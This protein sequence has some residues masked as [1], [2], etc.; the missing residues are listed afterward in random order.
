M[1]QAVFAVFLAFL[2]AWTHAA[3]ESAPAK[4]LKAIQADQ[5]KVSEKFS[6]DYGKAKTD[7]DRKK[8]FEAMQKE[9]QKCVRRALK[10]ATE[11]PKDPAAFEARAWIV[12]GG[13][14]FFPETWLALDQIREYD[15]ANPKI[16]RVCLHARIFRNFYAGTEDFLRSVIKQNPDHGVQGLAV[17]SLA[18]VLQDYAGV[19]ERLKDPAKTTPF[20][21]THPRQLVERLRAIT[22]EKLRRESEELY[23]RAADKYGDVKLPWG[24]RTLG[25][26]AESALFELRYLQIGK[27]APDIEG[28]DIDGRKLRLSDYR[29]KVVVLDFWGDW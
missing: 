14:G 16:G 8:A 6:A 2:P 9:T 27:M 7:A 21:R 25:K 1:R 28:P 15:L 19:S 4:A 5:E 22:P 24:D 18:I 26:M 12:T 3:D 10:L 11:H 20:D 23:Q 17:Y 13:L 29:G